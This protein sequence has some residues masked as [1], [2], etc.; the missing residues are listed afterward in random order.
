[1]LSVDVVALCLSL[2]MDFY[3]IGF[4]GCVLAVFLIGFVGGGFAMMLW[5]KKI[6][7]IRN[8]LYGN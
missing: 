2:A 1:M 5:Q 4:I 8:Q 6:Y 3:L 7:G